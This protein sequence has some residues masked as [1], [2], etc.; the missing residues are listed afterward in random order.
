MTIREFKDVRKPSK[1]HREK[2]VKGRQ[3]ALSAGLLAAGLVTTQ[4]EGDP[5][6]F[7]PNDYEIINSG[8]HTEYAA[9]Q[10]GD[11]NTLNLPFGSYVVAPTGELIVHSGPIRDLDGDGIENA[12]E[13]SNGNG[14]LFD[15][16][17]DGDLVPNFIDA[18]PPVSDTNGDGVPDGLEDTDGNG[19]L[20][21]DDA[22]GDH[23]PDYAD[24]EKLVAAPLVSAVYDVVSDRPSGVLLDA[25]ILVLAS[26]GTAAAGLGVLAVIEN[27]PTFDPVTTTYISEAAANSTSPDN[28]AGSTT[29]ALL[30][31]DAYKDGSSVADTGI[32]YSFTS[33]NDSGRFSIASDGKITVADAYQI[34]FEAESSHD[35]VVRATDAS[36]GVYRDLNVTIDVDDEAETTPTA[37]TTTTFT[38]QENNSVAATSIVGGGAINL[39]T[40]PTDTKWELDAQAT[41]AGFSI[42]SSGNLVLPVIDL[43]NLPSGMTTTSYSTPGGSDGGSIALT[44]NL[45]ATSITGS[46]SDHT[47]TVNIDGVHD[48]DPDYTGVTK[49]FSLDENADGSG[50]AVTLTS[51]LAGIYDDGEYSPGV[52]PTFDTTGITNDPDFAISSAGVITYTGTGED[53]ETTSSVTLNYYVNDADGGSKS[54]SVV[55]YINDLSPTT[56]TST[57]SGTSSGNPVN[58]TVDANQHYASIFDVNMT[59]GASSP[60]DVGLSYQITSTA[61]ADG[62]QFGIDSDGNIH[63]LCLAADD[64]YPTVTSPYRVT[65]EATETGG[66]ATQS[67]DFYFHLM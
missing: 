30:D 36:R 10:L 31:I 43:E 58:F 45:K 51:T 29:G 3:V 61:N 33:G 59:E 15:D 37:P 49:S 19:S 2:P 48:E 47:I 53:A 8:Q 34:D 9:L 16:D 42:D 13:D 60:A 50:T 55:V 23:I 57:A 63:L 64:P 39:G 11:G 1:H 44:F 35:L 66:T 4:A 7:G 32:T 65:V 6:V 38:I 21:N 25:G 52:A 28:T 26:S 27:R 56:D 24:T 5:L 40:Y 20:L 12:L 14:N 22:D 18:L 17:D 62:T 67:Q 54:D 41:A 46:D